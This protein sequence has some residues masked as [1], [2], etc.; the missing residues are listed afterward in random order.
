MKSK[1]LAFLCLSLLAT[2]GTA[3]TR[4]AQPNGANIL[5]QRLSW[6][7]LDRYKKFATWLAEQENPESYQVCDWADANGIRVDLY[8]NEIDSPEG[9]LLQS[10]EDI[11]HLRLVGIV[12]KTSERVSWSF[13]HTRVKPSSWKQW[14]AAY[15]LPAVIL[16]AAMFAGIAL[17][18][19][20]RN[21]RFASQTVATTVRAS[22]VAPIMS[23][24]NERIIGMVSGSL[25]GYPA[26]LAAQE[27]LKKE[28]KVGIYESV[29]VY[30]CETEGSVD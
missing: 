3:R 2:T 21:H 25:I 7:E 26:V 1:A 9:Y 19:R 27:F 23:A 24:L 12:N 13:Q 30:A 28:L 10:S 20:A 22:D 16:P 17:S 14:S 6:G 11:G 18:V 15:G 4:L 29:F 5:Q 8:S